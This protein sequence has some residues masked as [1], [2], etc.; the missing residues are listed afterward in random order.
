MSGVWRI[1]HGDSPEQTHLSLGESPSDWLVTVEA[2][3]RRIYEALLVAIVEYLS[4]CYGEPISIRQ[5]E[6]LT[7]HLAKAFAWR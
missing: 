3:A 6:I 7:G 2:D 4:E 1:S 5:A